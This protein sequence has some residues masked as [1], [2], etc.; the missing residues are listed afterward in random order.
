[1]KKFPGLFLWMM[2]ILDASAQEWFPVGASWYY[3]QVVLLEGEKYLYFHVEGETEI[4]G[5]TCRII[6]GACNCGL[7]NI[8][9]YFYQ[10]GDKIFGFNAEADSFN[11]FF[12]F[13]L[14]PGDTLR[15]PANSII[16][17]EILH[18]IDSI[19]WIQVGTL[20]LRVQHITTL[21]APCA[22]GSKIIERIGSDLCFYP[23]FIFCDPM[24]GGL[25]CYEDGETGLFNFQSPPRDCNYNSVS[26]ADISADRGLNIYP[27]PTDGDLNFA[28][29]VDIE[30]ITI[31]NILGLPVAEHRSLYQ[32]QFSLALG[33]LPEALYLVRVVYKD[34]A[35][36]VE[37]IHVQH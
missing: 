1:M 7:S 8:K 26:T 28:S 4:Q 37:S 16:E 21:N 27:N 14:L 9:R 6:E 11:L 18:L 2:L 29:D 3:N 22:W 23:Q 15:H 13:T 5:K 30:S 33:S 36:S 25:R 31:M 35:V 32:R 34:Q 17:E 19:T 12:D 20:N 10:E 24:T